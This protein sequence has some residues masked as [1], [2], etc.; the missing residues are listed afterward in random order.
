MR[1]CMLCC[2]VLRRTGIPALLLFLS[3]FA[4]CP[5]VQAQIAGG[6]GGGLGGGGL[7]GGGFGGGGRGG[8]GGGAGAAGGIMI[9]PQGVVHPVFAADPNARLDKKRK[10]EVAGK[11]LPADLNRFS[12]LR[13]VSLVRLEAACEQ[14]A[15]DRKH[16][17]TDLEYL[18][19]LQRIDYVFVYPETKDL[20]I[21]GPAE[22]FLL[23]PVGRAVGVSTGRPPLRL[24]DLLVA[25]RAVEAGGT[26]G[27]SIDPVPE[28]LAELEAYVR[29]NSSAATPDLIKERFDRMARILGMQDVRVFGVPPDSHF[30]EALVEA[31][32]RMKMLSIGKETAPVKGLKSH[33]ALIGAGQNTMQRWWFTPLYDAFVKSQDGLAFEFS[34]QRVQLLSQEEL[35]ANGQRSNAPFTRVSTTAWSKLLTDKYP[36]LANVSPIFAELQS[37][38][39]LAVFA[40]LCRKE[41][42]PQQVGWGMELFRDAERASLVKRPVPRQVPTTMNYKS[43]GTRL[44]IGLVAGGV[45]I[46]PQQTVNRTDYRSDSEGK[47]KSAREES[48]R[49]SSPAEKSPTEKSPAETSNSAKAPEEHPWW[50]D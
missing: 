22:G 9:D 39:D 11:S 48:V 27:C 21:A 20:V 3:A 36:E 24:D 14:Y 33:L 35:T 42:L 43:R 50:W 26:L 31:D 45:T 6:G 18:A 49:E 25:L 4:I 8:A 5:P 37:L 10:A 17:S 30:A 16:V 41:R 38:F 12:P 34:G 19:G 1:S 28:R 29:E 47:L 7:G 40:A 15:K 46:N 23:D 44:F 2:S 13:K 32:Y